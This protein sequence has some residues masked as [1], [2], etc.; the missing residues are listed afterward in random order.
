M[1]RILPLFLDRTL[2]LFFLERPERLE[3]TLAP[4]LLSYNE[5]KKA[6][7]GVLTEAVRALL[8]LERLDTAPER[9]LAPPL[10]SYSECK[11]AEFGVLTEAVRALLFREERPAL[12]LDVA[13]ERTLLFLERLDTAAER[14]LA[15]L[16][17]P[18]SECK[19]AE[20]GVL[21]EAVRALLF[22]EE[23]PALFLDVAP[24]RT[25]LFLERLD[26]AAER[27]LAP[28]LLPYSECKKAESGVLFL[29]P[30]GEPTIENTGEF[31]TCF[32]IHW[33]CC[34]PFM[35]FVHMFIAIRWSSYK[36]LSGL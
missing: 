26:T 21:T 23:R 7:F 8:F 20:F 30:L 3:R 13:P 34:S 36:D 29:E 22:R 1:E 24:E 4:P 9:T 12:F 2:L 15:P 32:W 28:L 17:L 11:K 6:E 19:K 14:T 25:L 33:F 16:L 5:C 35:S 18:Y 10:L 27:T 31:R